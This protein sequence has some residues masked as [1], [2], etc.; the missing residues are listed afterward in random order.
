LSSERQVIQV[1]KAR[2]TRVSPP[3]AIAFAVTLVAVGLLLPLVSPVITPPKYDEFIITFDAQRLLNG[4]LPHRDYF[5]FV[6]PVTSYVLAAAYWPFGGGSLTVARYTS[7][8]VVLLG[9]LALAAAFARA[10]WRTWEALLLSAL[11]PLCFYPFWPVA[12]HHWMAFL[13]CA[14]FLWIVTDPRWGASWTGSIATG[15]LAGVALGTIQTEGAYLTLAAG[16]LLIV[17]Q[18][19]AAPRERLRAWLGVALGGTAAVGAIYGPLALAGAWPRMVDDLLLWPA[20]N[21]NKPGNDNARV[22][23]EDLPVRFGQL[24]T[25]GLP[26][27][28]PV[29]FAVS[30]A[31]TVMHALLLSAAV[32]VLLSALFVA[33]RAAKERAW[34]DPVQA[35]ASAVT[36]AACYLYLKG[37]PDWLHMLYPLALLGALWLIAAGRAW[38]G[39]MPKARRAVA[40]LGAILALS[41]ALYFSRRAMVHSSAWL[42]L[43]DVDRPVREYVVNRFLRD[44]KVLPPGGCVAAFPEGGEVYLYG[45]K[46]AVGFTLLFPLQAGLNDLA[47]HTRAA[48]D[49]ARNR[50]RWIIFRPDVEQGFLDPASPVGVIVA[51]DYTRRGELGAAVLYER[52]PGNTGA[53]GDVTP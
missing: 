34:R 6:P 35:V 9:W 41:G 10:G 8:L 37:R 20:R 4:Q 46:P 31:G 22:L 30:A 14:A 27:V 5:S 15:A 13:V 43:N 53:S 23:L 52:I 18:R 50:P 39:R 16:V 51:R 40:A 36:V 32:A 1:A 25:D 26:L 29:R 44:P 42:E 49:L 19:G 45:P 38:R 33:L 12:S 7:L 21:Y 3:W 48:R 2:K 28:A 47:D 17:G 24:W 11:Y